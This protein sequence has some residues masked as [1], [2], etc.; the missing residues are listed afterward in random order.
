[1]PAA[2]D[3]YL[4]HLEVSR[5]L[6]PNSLEAYSRDLM[7]LE[8]FAEQKQLALPAL[9]LSHLEEFVRELMTSG[10]APTSAAR[11]VAGVRGFYKFLRLNGAISSN[12]AEDLHSPRT[13]HA[14]PKFHL[15][16]R[17]KVTVSSGGYFSVHADLFRKFVRLRHDP[18]TQ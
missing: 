11:M 1:M 7:R 6:A 13:F 10:L 15:Q 16:V 4:R 9:T 12:P 17:D 8:A 3:T 14:L 2:V 18:R 5:R